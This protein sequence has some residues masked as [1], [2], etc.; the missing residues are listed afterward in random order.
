MRLPL[1][2]MFLV[3]PSCGLM[4]GLQTAGEL[5]KIRAEVQDIAKDVDVVLSDAEKAADINKNGKVDGGYE[6]LLLL[7]LGCGGLFEVG[8]RKLKGQEAKNAE[9]TARIEHERERR[10]DAEVNALRSDL[11]LPPKP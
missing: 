11:D 5:S 4:Q 3:L 1:L 10:K 7:L 9:L 2:L 8:R 6:Q